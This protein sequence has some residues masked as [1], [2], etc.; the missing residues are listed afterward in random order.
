MVDR[1]LAAALRCFA[2]DLV[3][4]ATISPLRTMARPLVMAAVA[5]AD[6]AASAV[7]TTLPPPMPGR[8]QAAEEEASALAVDASV[9]AVVA[10]VSRLR[11]MVPRVEELSS[12]WV[13]VVAHAALLLRTTVRPQA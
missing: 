5:L 9:A 1:R 13:A 8:L 7:A 10:P 6:A 3:A 2:S 11:T 12:A 4:A